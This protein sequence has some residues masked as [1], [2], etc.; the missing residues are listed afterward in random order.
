M[1]YIR[2]TVMPA[3]STQIVERVTVLF[4]GRV[5]GVGFRYCVKNLA[6]QH[7]LTG[8]VRNTNDGKVE[9]VMEG[10][11][12]EREALVRAVRDKMQ[13]Y[14]RHVD[15]HTSAGTGEFKDFSIRH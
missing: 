13:D 5:Q 12:S 8:Y 7:A 10:A 4:T 6:L 3:A 9:L 2:R 1:G 14:I 15:R 11:E